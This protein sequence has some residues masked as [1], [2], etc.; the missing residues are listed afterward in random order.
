MSLMNHLSKKKV[1]KIITKTFLL[2]FYVLTPCAFWIKIKKME[3]VFI[4]FALALKG[5]C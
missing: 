5:D 1:S 3:Q 4:N 2:L